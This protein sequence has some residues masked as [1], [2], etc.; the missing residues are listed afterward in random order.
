[1]AMENH[2]RQQVAEVYTI[3]QVTE[4]TG[5][6]ENTIR[7]WERRFGLPTPE[8]S[9]GK[10]RRYAR[11]EIDMIRAI[12]EARDAGRTMEQA[13]AAATASSRLRPPTALTL[14]ESK[15][16]APEPEE[17][18]GSERASALTR[19][20]RGELGELNLR[21]ANDVLSDAHLAL[22]VEVVLQ[23]VVL[24]V[25]EMLKQ[26]LVRGEL[27]QVIW[28]QTRNWIDRKLMA[29][30]E[31]SSPESGDLHALIVGLDEAKAPSMATA[32]GVALSRGGFQTT[33]ID[34]GPV[35]ATVRN[36]LM[37]SR[38]DCVVLHASTTDGHLAVGGAVKLIEE[39]RADGD[40]TGLV[41]HA[42]DAETLK[43]I[44]PARG[45]GD[46][47][48]TVARHLRQAFDAHS[49]TNKETHDSR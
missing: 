7:S 36:L 28:L 24:A 8:R 21:G 18:S 13:I 41:V 46:D 40:W 43:D 6:P 35:P 22:P 25:S 47:T 3:S 33:T 29:A 19:R 31:A 9:A 30:Y 26:R 49:M 2:D 14:V 23:H 1:M 39:I 12:Q 20:L 42:C 45:I 44:P 16:T 10:Q 4:M 32:L 11:S 37:S 17:H 27:D 34:I 15:L 5:V 48:V 38:P